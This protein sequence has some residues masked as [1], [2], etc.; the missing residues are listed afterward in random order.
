[1]T[2]A[3]AQRRTRKAEAIRSLP[4]VLIVLPL[5]LLAAAGWS[6]VLTSWYLS[7]T[8]LWSLSPLIFHHYHSSYS[9][10]TDHNLL[11]STP[12]PSTPAQS[13]L[14]S[15][16]LPTCP[17]CLALS[18]GH[19][20]ATTDQSSRTHTHPP[21][22]P[23]PSFASPQKGSSVSPPSLPPPPTSKGHPPF[24][25]KRR[26]TKVFPARH[27]SYQ[28]TVDVHCASHTPFSQLTHSTHSL[29]HL[30]TRPFSLPPQS[31]P[32]TWTRPFL[33]IF[34]LLSNQRHFLSNH[35]DSTSANLP[36]DPSA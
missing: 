3:T 2:H 10:H 8:P 20:Q 11:R 25:Q 5:T 24:P 22:S 36:R 29:T 21:F 30:L 27:N 16:H 32:N 18:T 7:S 1:M 35:L 17:A 26:L 19:R 23:L 14:L 34:R 13:T 9:G 31:P 4:V 12:V 33:A 15:T 6:L 28:S